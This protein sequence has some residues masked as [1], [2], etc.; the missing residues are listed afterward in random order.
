MW[1]YICEPYWLAALRAGVINVQGEGHLSSHS[2][3]DKMRNTQTNKI[4]R[5]DALRW[6]L[7]R[8]KL[9]GPSEIR[10]RFLAA[11]RSKLLTE[12]ARLKSLHSKTGHCRFK[13]SH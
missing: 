5:L 13:R 1:L 6:R 12:I 10:M 9:Y 3:L 11:V 8:I 4:V 2:A 7:N